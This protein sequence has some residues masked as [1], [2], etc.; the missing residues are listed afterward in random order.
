[1]LLRYSSSIKLRRKKRKH[2]RVII[3]VICALGARSREGE[4]EVRKSGLSRSC[5]G[6]R[7]ARRTAEMRFMKCIRDRIRD[8]ERAEA[9]LS[10]ATQ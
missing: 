3:V 4:D 6:G 9:E 1:M 7:T 5:Y 8:L 10:E 2:K